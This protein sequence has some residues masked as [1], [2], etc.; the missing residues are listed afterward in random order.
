MNAAL[1]GVWPACPTPLAE[2][3]DLDEE[4]MRRV[5]RFLVEGGI[6]GLWLFGSGGEGVLLS[7]KV[8]RRAV[9]VVLEEVA[10]SIPVLVGVSAEGTGRALA[11]YRHLADLPFAGVFATPPFFYVYEQREIAEFYRALAHE[12]G[13]PLVVYNNPYAAKVGLEPETIAQLTEVEGIVGVKDSSG[14]FIVTQSILARVRD[15]PD[16]SVLQGF[17]TLAAASLLAGANGIVS[18]VACFAP[19]LPVE[20]TEAAQLG[21]AERTFVLQ[22]QVTELLD[23]LAWDPYSDAAFIRGV[24]VCL[25]LMGLCSARVAHPFAQASDEER[26]STREALQATVGLAEI[27]R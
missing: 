17:D 4:G 11:R 20:L 3:D 19:R 1:H 5:V 8:R 16:F 25:E 23:R 2:R 7:D 27:V 6:H 9:E 18:A 12:I 15:V 14:N 24:K 26:R 10:E 22:R 13:R 21:D